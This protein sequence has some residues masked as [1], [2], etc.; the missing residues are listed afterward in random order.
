M[1]DGKTFKG[2]FGVV[3]QDPGVLAVVEGEH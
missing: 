2:A 3:K 1:G